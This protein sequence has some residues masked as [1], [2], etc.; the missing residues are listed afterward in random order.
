V[1]APIAAAAA[2]AYMNLLS[3]KNVGYSGIKHGR[4]LKRMER[5]R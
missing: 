4:G 2:A 3:I 5:G 1:W